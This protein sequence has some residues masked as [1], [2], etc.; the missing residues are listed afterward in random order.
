MAGKDGKQNVSSA[1]SSIGVPPGFPDYP[2]ES[3]PSWL[4]QLEK[5]LAEAKAENATI[6]EDNW[7]LKVRIAALESQGR[8]MAEELPE[9]MSTPE[10]VETAP[11]AEHYSVGTPSACGDP[12]RLEWTRNKSH[13]QTS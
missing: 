1:A 6:K 13:W 2:V 8:A 7:A 11:G 9:D 4:K 12:R 5:E 3:K 10:G